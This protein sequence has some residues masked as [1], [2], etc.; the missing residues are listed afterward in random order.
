MI[1]C[2]GPQFGFLTRKI[3]LLTKFIRSEKLL[4]ATLPGSASDN[5]EKNKSNS[6]AQSTPTT[7]CPMT[8]VCLLLPSLLPRF[9]TQA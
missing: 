7:A 8:S 4:I 9:S 2:S 6:L 5:S 3:S 1:R